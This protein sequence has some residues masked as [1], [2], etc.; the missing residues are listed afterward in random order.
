VDR[1]VHYQ[2]EFMVKSQEQT[3]YNT[4]K[5]TK[6]IVNTDE[7]VIEKA[8]AI[9]ESRVK[10]QDAIEYVEDTVLLLRLKYAIKDREHFVVMYLD[11][12]NTVIETETLF[13]GTVNECPV[14]PREVFRSALRHNAVNI[15]LCH[16][17]PSG[18]TEPSQADKKLTDIVRDLGENLDI[19]LLDHII[20][21]NKGYYSFAERGI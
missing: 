6:A 9:L 11:N 13:I 16:N 17:H 12:R 7:N 14:R 15:I 8:I 5:I 3:K 18:V 21:T 10:M 20:V 2:G 4:R 1:E 19:R